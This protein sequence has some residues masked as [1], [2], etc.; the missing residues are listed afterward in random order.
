[1]KRVMIPRPLLMLNNKN[2]IVLWEQVFSFILK[3]T[4]VATRLKIKG[5]E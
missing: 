1:M 2:K 3:K 4:N 5:E